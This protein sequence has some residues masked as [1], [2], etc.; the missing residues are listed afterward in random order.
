L[1]LIRKYFF[2]PYLY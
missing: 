2:K 1:E